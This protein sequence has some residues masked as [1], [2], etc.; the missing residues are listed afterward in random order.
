MGPLISVIVPV[1]NAGAR[2]ERCLDSLAG[3]THDRLEVLLV[4]DGS[5]DES[6]ALCDRRAAADSRFRVIHQPNG[7]VSRARN[8]GLEEAAGGY[9]SFVD[10]DDWVEP[11]YCAAL[12]E[13]AQSCGAEI[14]YCK[15]F[16]RRKRRDTGQVLCWSQGTYT[17]LQRHAHQ[18]C[19]GAVYRRELLEGL[20]FREELHMGEDSLFFAQAVKK[21]ERVACRDVSLYHYVYDPDS[22]ANRAFSQR[23]YAELTAWQEICRLYQDC[24][25]VGEQC[26]G[27]YALRCGMMLRR[28]AADEVFRRDYRRQVLAEYRR[29]VGG[30]LR[31]YRAERAV[32][33][34]AKELLFL[35]CPGIWRA[36]HRL[37]L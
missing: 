24:P 20:R 35:L 30:L 28:Y 4:D 18:T 1:Y 36:Y 3:Q 13:L 26:V 31:Y 29:T 19:W 16:H 37:W 22:A 21:A 12:L 27:A 11:E 23:R 6:P 8:R 7:G 14:A 5:T 10:A 33:P 25:G 17:W 2:L 15:E 34:L 9:V 32:L